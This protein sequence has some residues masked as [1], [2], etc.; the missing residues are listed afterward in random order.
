MKDLALLEGTNILV[1]ITGSIAVYKAADLV[2]RMKRGGGDVVVVMTAAARKFMEPITFRI[3]SENPVYT[4]LFQETAGDEPLHIGLAGAA[5]LL[6]VAPATADFIARAAGGLANDLL[7]SLILAFTGPV[8]I[9]PAMN[10]K[11]YH[12]PIVRENILRLKKRGCHFVGPDSGYLACGYEG[13]GRLTTTE[14]ILEKI[15]SLLK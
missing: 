15:I 1:G 14:K 7:S 12:N 2:S 6:L 10:E 3:L 11:M 5:D 8:L 4:D 13:E 9:A